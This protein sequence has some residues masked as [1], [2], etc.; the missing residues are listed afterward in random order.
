M[1]DA[2]EILLSVDDQASTAVAKAATKVNSIDTSARASKPHVIALEKAG[3]SAGDAIGKIGDTLDVPELGRAAGSIGLIAEHLQTAKEASNGLKLGFVGTLGVVGGVA[4]GA[5]SIGK[6]IGDVVFQ[7]EYWNKQLQA[8]VSISQQLAQRQGRMASRAF[9]DEM[10]F[11][12]LRDAPDSAYQ[13][14]IAKI[15]Q[16]AGGIAKSLNAEL[17]KIDSLSDPVSSHVYAKEIELRQNSANLLQ[18]QLEQLKE[19]EVTIERMLG[20]ERELTREREKKGRI[21]GEDRFIKQLQDELELLTATA[22]EQDRI[23]AARNAA[24]IEGQAAIELLLRS[25][26]TVESDLQKAAEK[27]ELAKLSGSPKR[28]PD[29][30]TQLD[31]FEARLLTRGPQQP[32]QEELKELKNISKQLERQAKALEQSSQDMSKLM[33]EKVVIAAPNGR[34]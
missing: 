33:R 1:S 23:I 4:A 17:A 10:A 9:G 31:G 24:T 30:L 11:L 14:L 29:R 16:E 26:R 20:V 13:Q 3:R 18:Q 27:K 7:T 25:K 6:A 22:E 32:G 21:E 5:F 12:E 19:Q 2:V 15:K 28:Q 34:R 8:A